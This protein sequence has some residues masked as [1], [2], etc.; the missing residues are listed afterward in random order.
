MPPVLTASVN[1]KVRASTGT[2]YQVEVF[3]KPG[4]SDAAGAALLSQLATLG[5]TA[6]SEIKIGTLYDIRGSYSVNQIIAISKELLADPIA[7]DFAINHQRPAGML[8]SA[9]WRIEVRLK[10]AVTDP[11]ESSLR[12]AVVDLGLAE[13]EMARA[14]VVY[15]FWGRLYPCQAEKITLKLLANPVVHNYTVESC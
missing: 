14:G 8:W 3:N 13:P 12:K 4:F 10:S 6:V 15:K 9:H 1:G 7:Q 2:T 5:I 11:V